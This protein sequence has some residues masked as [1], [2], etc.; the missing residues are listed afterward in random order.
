MKQ[1]QRYCIGQ[2][3]M[4]C[5]FTLFYKQE[6]DGC[7]ALFWD[8]VYNHDDFLNTHKDCKS[9]LEICSGPGFIGWGIAHALGIEEVH[10]GD[11]HEPVNIDL[12]KTA[13]FNNVDYNFHLSDG[14]KSYKGPKVDLIMV[15]PP[16]FTKIEQ[17]EHF[18][19]HY[20]T[21]NTE[22]QVEHHKRRWLDLDMNLHI[23]VLN[24]FSKYLNENGR[25][26]ILA[27]KEY[28]DKDMLDAEAKNYNR[29][30]YKEFNVKEKPHWHSYIR[31]Y[32]I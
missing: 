12:A 6:N 26:V 11:I 25:C 16:F 10:F 21:L 22:E 30:T 20:S 24:N 31:T 7:G 1:W 14:F 19:E 4:D 23:N 32:Y 18:Q 5:D 9:I 2:N 27:D 3:L 29:S 8:A 13:E 17:F 28:I 15:S